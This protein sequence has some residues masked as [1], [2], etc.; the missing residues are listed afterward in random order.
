MHLQN[1]GYV[2][3]LLI[4]VQSI[5]NTYSTYLNFLSFS[6]GAL[7]VGVMCGI[8]IALFLIASTIVLSLIPTFLPAHG[9]YVKR[10]K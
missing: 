5:S 3:P 9:S 6:A 10:R 8:G 7:T 4:H 1:F 2:T